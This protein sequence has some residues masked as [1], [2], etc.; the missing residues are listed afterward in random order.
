MSKPAKHFWTLATDE[1]LYA[2]LATKDYRIFKQHLYRPLYLLAHTVRLQYDKRGL[3]TTE[4]LISYCW[5]TVFP[6]ITTKSDKCLYN[7]FYKALVYHIYELLKIE[8]LERK[9]KYRNLQIYEMRKDIY[10]LD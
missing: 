9:K 7:Y 8:T 3:T 6:K 5:Y 2:Y 10:Q 4:A 1:R